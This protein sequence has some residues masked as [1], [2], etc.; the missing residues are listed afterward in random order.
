MARDLSSIPTRRPFRGA[1]ELRQGGTDSKAEAAPEPAG[2]RLS[3]AL[4]SGQFAGR[5]DTDLLHA[6]AVVEVVGPEIVPTVELVLGDALE[7]EALLEGLAD[8]ADRLAGAAPPGILGHVVP[9]E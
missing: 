5:E 2:R 1:T 3:Y 4:P 9:D 7:P 8:D 6:V